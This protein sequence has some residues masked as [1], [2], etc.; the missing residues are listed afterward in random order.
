MTALLLTIAIPAAAFAAIVYVTG[1]LQRPARADI[2]PA[3]RARDVLSGD[4]RVDVRRRQ[5][6]EVIR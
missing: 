6:I 2:R 3:Q 4:R 1:K 5:R